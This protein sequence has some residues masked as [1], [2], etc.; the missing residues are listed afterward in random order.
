MEGRERPAANF[1]KTTEVTTVMTTVTSGDKRIDKY[2]D[3]K[4]QD[5]DYLLTKVNKT[6]V[7]LLFS[8]KCDMGREHASREKKMF[9]GNFFIFVHKNV[10][11]IRFQKIKIGPLKGF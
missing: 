7:F 1:T 9:H 2:D 6:N 11:R 10:Y 5:G 4:R 3:E 8:H